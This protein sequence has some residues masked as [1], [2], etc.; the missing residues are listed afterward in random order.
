MNQWTGQYIKRLTSH[1]VLSLCSTLSSPRQS[2]LSTLVFVYR[3]DLP[4]L[5]YY[6]SDFTTMKFLANLMAL[7]ALAL[8]LALAK[9]C[10]SG[11]FLYSAKAECVPLNGNTSRDAESAPYVLALHSTIGTHT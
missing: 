1:V 7:W 8:P 11:Q 2:G 10:S 9:S 3:V 5:T 4:I 6:W